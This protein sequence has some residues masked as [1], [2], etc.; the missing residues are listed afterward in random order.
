ME[1]EFVPFQVRRGLSVWPDGKTLAVAI[2]LAVEDC[3]DDPSGY[4]MTP[5]PL[6]PPLLPHMSRPDLGIR[7]SMEYGYR[8]GVWRVMEVLDR[9]AVKVSI[10]GNGLAAER[11]PALFRDFVGRGYDLVA[12]GYDQSRLFTQLSPEEQSKD[13]DRTLKVFEDVTGERVPGWGSPWARQ[14]QATLDLLAERDLVFH[15]GLHD[16]ELPYLLHFGKRTMVEIPYRITESGE[17]ND[18]WMYHPRDCLVE[19][20]AMRYCRALI[21]ARYRDSAIRPQLLVIGSHP[22]V[23]GR[24]DHIE[25]LAAVIA[26]LKTLPNA[27]LTT[28]GGIANRWQKIARSLPVATM[29]EKC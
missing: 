4:T 21:D 16:D 22:E 3:N 23:T 24:P 13:I 6:A 2:Y 27:W 25:T 11:H 7:S 20:E 5:S 12:H 9:H 19:D 1:K 15:Q 17:L 8:V 26:Y 14:Y 28:M 10:I 29:R 18:Y